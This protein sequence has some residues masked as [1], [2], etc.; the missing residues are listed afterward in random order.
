MNPFLRLVRPKQWTKNLLVF[1]ALLFTASWNDP[2]ALQAS[3]IAFLSL[4]LLSSASYVWN[5]LRD[6][7]ADRAHPVKRHRPIA[8][9]LVGEQPASVLLLILFFGGLGAALALP[10]GAQFGLA[11][12]AI[13]QIL[14][15]IG[16][17]SYSLLDIALVSLAFVTRAA[18]GALACQVPISGWLLFCTGALALMLISAKRRQEWVA[19]GP[20]SASRAS[21]AG[22]SQGFLDALVV[23]SATLGAL[24]FGIYAIESET[25]RAHPALLLT[26]PFVLFGILRYLQLVFTTTEGE[27]PESLLLRDPLLLGTVALFVLVAAA[28][29]SGLQAPFVQVRP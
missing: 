2:R 17:K 12:F 4:C 13:L 23:F 15:N 5:D 22:Y 18:V 20:G 11:G 10:P 19:L 6:A 8:A 24:S 29:M 25:A 1:A 26:T 21:L 27:E 9:G 16:V 14:Y 3:L 7:E 28:A